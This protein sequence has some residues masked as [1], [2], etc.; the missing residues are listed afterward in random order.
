MTQKKPPEEKYV[1]KSFTLPPEMDRGIAHWPT[2]KLTAVIRAA[3][4]QELAR[5]S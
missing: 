5:S 4:T 3:I 1:K 2:G